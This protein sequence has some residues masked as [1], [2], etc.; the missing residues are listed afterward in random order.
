MFKEFG[1]LLGGIFVGAVTAEIIRKKCPNVGGTLR[2]KICNVTS[3]VKDAFKA[4]YENATKHHKGAGDV[5]E[6][7][8]DIGSA[9]LA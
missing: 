7:A 3:G 9:Q 5:A 4:G 6:P 2:T 8:S 1:I